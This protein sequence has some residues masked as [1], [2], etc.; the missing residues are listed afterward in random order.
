L[1]EVAVHPRLMSNPGTINAVKGFRDILPDETRR[2]RLFDDAAARVFGRYG[3][4]EIGLPIV[5]RTDLF[6]RSI[7]DTTDIV[8]KEMYSFVDRDGT[9]LTLRPEATAGVVRAYLESGLA[10]RDPT[11]RL[12]YRGP[13]F[14]RER[15]QRGRYRQFHQIGVE[16]F[17]RDDPLVDAELLMMLARYLDDVGARDTHLELNSVGDAVCLPVY[18]ERLRAFGTAHL[19]GLCPDCHRRLERNPLR[20]L[21]CK[22]ESCR[23]IVADAPVVLDSLCDGCRAHLDAVRSLLEQQ[24][25][26]YTMNPRLVRGL[27]YYTR[28]AFE[29]VGV[30][31]GAQNAVGGGGRYDGLVAALGGP[32]VAGIGFALGVERLAM[33]VPPEVGADT[34]PAVAVLPL[35]PEAVGPAFALAT[36]LRDAGFGAALEPAGRSLKALLRAADRRGA[37]L[38]VI[39]GEDELGAGR[40]TVRDLAR[41]EDRRQALALDAPSAALVETIRSMLG[42]DA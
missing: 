1:L 27:D 14:R 37:R 38:A 35:A 19:A 32:D 28:T 5:E 2:W 12:Y 42:G 29:V 40:A 16:A 9:S 39:L 31:L 34:R 23:R 4:E 41:H 8:E 3:F 21:D 33:V 7:G 20:I 13:M 25:V 22:V 10:Q 30:G 36:R 18:R 15:P 11:A 17:G 6:A 26:P 24:S